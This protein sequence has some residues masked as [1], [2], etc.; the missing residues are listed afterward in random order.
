MGGASGVSHA[1][2]TKLASKSG[3]GSAEKG[4]GGGKGGVCNKSGG[5]RGDRK[6]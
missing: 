4:G 2:V 3:L 5:G 1:K 6:R